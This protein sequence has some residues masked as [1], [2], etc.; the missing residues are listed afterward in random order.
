[1]I[2]LL[3]VAVAY[4]IRKSKELRQVFENQ[5]MKRNGEVNGFFSNI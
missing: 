2:V 4:S 1:M 5:A 3:I